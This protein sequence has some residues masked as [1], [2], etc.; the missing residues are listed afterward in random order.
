MNNLPNR[1]LN[2][3]GDYTGSG[4]GYD[5]YPDG[6]VINFKQANGKTSNFQRRSYRK[7]PDKATG[8]TGLLAYQIGG[9][10]DVIFIMFEVPW[11]SYNFV[12]FSIDRITGK[13]MDGMAKFSKDELSSKYSW[14]YNREPNWPNQ[15]MVLLTNTQTKQNFWWGDRDATFFDYK[16]SVRAAYGGGRDGYCQSFKMI[17][18][19][20][21]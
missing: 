1:V 16:F 21:K 3:V 20:N 15:N 4:T 13:Y 11:S 12:G 6:D 8:S 19:P 2:F 14:F 18:S 10:A 7:I 17:I 9:T 5:V